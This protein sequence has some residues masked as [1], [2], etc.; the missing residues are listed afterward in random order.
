M[1]EL[2]DPRGPIRAIRPLVTGLIAAAALAGA[3]C[4]DRVRGE[5]TAAAEDL[6]V[7][8]GQENVLTVGRDT[9]VTGPLVSGELRARNEA[10]LRAQVGGSVLEVRAEEGES[11]RK[12][13]VLARI[14]ARSLEDTRRSAAT[15]VR[16]AEQALELAERETARVEKLVDAGALA[17]REVDLARNNVTA[18]QAQLDDARSRLASAQEQLNDTVIRAPISG[19]VADRAVNAGDVVAVGTELYTVVDPSSMRL[20]ANVPS[21]SLGELRV[22]AP[23]SIQVRGLNTR[24]EGTIERIAP[25]TDS[26][27]RQLPIYV[28]IPNVSGRLVGGLFAE[29]RVITE[30]ATGLVVPTNAVNSSG[31]TPWV[32]KVVDGRTVRADVTLG[33]RDPRTERVEVTAGLAEGDILLRGAAQGIAPGTPV[34]LAGRR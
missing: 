27:T 22:G 21:E 16:S 24:V 31:E 18:A 12:G 30:S 7:L 13:A 3:A 34:E 2:L 20:E 26:A 19:V 10:V 6:P 5:E 14:G 32:L 1:N 33:L 28:A 29:G 9:L 4:Q 23:V 11:V 15:A 8:I 17:A 25:R